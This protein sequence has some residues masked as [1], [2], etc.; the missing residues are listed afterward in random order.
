MGS[1][2]RQAIDSVL[3]QTQPVHEILVVDDNSTDETPRILK[4][5][6]DR[7]R[8]LAGPGIGSAVSRNIG[9][10]AATGEYIAFLDADD[11]WLSEKVRHQLQVMV[12]ERGQFSFTDFYSGDSP[13]AERRSVLTQYTAVAGGHVF[14]NLLR[15]NFVLTSSVMIRRELFGRIGLLKPGL[16]GGQDFDLWL[17]MARQVPFVP[18]REVLTF[19]RRHSGNITNSTKYAYFHETVWAE[20][21]REHRDCSR[22]DRAYI[23]TRWAMAVHN[24]GRHAIR[25]LDPATARSYFTRAIAQHQALPSSVIWLAISCLPASLVRGLIRIKRNIAGD[26]V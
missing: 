4:T 13:D 19:Y 15:E 23:R 7:I 12:S 11:V 25:Q 6:G 2:V 16:R 17:R 26:A 22:E 3:S 5:Y 20:I 1:Y 21:E 9:I 10:L 24:A 8:V 14:S 18:I